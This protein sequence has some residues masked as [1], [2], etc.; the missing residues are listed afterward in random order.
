MKLLCLTGLISTLWLTSCGNQKDVTIE[1]STNS[2]HKI[3]PMIFGH[4]LEK[5]SWGGEIGIEA[6]FDNAKFHLQP[7]LYSLL[8]S[9][10]IP[11]L[12]FPGGTDIDHI[13]WRDMVSNIPGRE[14]KERPTSIGHTGTEVTNLFGYDEMLNLSQSL[15]AEPILVVNFGAGYYGEKLLRE[16]ANDAA[17]LVAYCNADLK[18][19]LPEELAIYPK[20]R[21]K[22]G[23]TDPW[24]VKYWQIANEPWVLDRNLKLNGDISDSLRN[25]YYD[26]INAYINAMRAVDPTI[27]IILDGNSHEL[28]QHLNKSVANYDLVAYHMYYPWQVDYYTRNGKEYL[29]DSLSKQEI[30]YSWT[31]MPQVDPQGFSILD[32]PG[33]QNAKI[34][35]KPIAVTEWNWNGWWGGKVGK[36]VPAS[37]FAKGVGAA[38]M[39]HSM[40]RSGN[41][42]MACQSMLVGNSWDIT[43]IRV[44]K[45]NDFAPYFFP[46]GLI[47]AFYSSLHGENMLRIKANNIPTIDQPYKMNE[48]DAKDKVALLD[49]LATGDDQHV[50]LHVINRAYDQ[51]LDATINLP[52]NAVSV[53]QH[54]YKGSLENLPPDQPTAWLEKNQ[55]AQTGKK[56]KVSFPKR[57]VSIVE[58]E[59]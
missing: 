3:N 19:T 24:K 52:Q 45:K 58:F 32:N 20:L 26:C 2:I 54:I 21:A 47:T 8:D 23:Q 12:R 40:M 48:V 51:D 1:I 50:F 43:G 42:E 18:D 17:A 6:A 53:I 5:P 27:K 22:N 9:M 25:H 29:P 38:G 57:T 44:D 46:S 35:Q 49:I 10:N 36:E 28:S 56:I 55:I 16:A 30:W 33:F 13:D 4:F 34:P 7:G 59:L 39:L 15:K 14:S 11:V 37:R 41:I 31:A